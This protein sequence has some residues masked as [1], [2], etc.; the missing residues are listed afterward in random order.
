[1]WFSVVCSPIDN[2]TRRH[3]GQNVVGS[4]DA[5]KCVRNKLGYITKRAPCY[6]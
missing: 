5:A 3:S 6:S 4:R 2:D 1:M